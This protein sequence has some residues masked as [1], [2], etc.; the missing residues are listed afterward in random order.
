MTSLGIKS[1][2]LGRWQGPSSEA[3]LRKVQVRFARIQR[4]IERRRAR[5][6]K[7]VILSAAT[8]VGILIGGGLL[9]G[10]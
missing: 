10:H 4:R 1:Q 8:F 6:W 7:L 3:R 5:P 9:L 2:T